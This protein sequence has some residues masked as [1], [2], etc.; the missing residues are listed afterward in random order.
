MRVYFIVYG[1]ALTLVQGCQVYIWALGIREIQGGSKLSGRQGW[2]NKKRPSYTQWVSTGCAPIMAPHHVSLHVWGSLLGTASHIL[3][4]KGLLEGISSCFLVS[5][6]ILEG[7]ASYIFH[8]K[9]TTESMLSYMYGNPRGHF[10]KFSHTQQHPKRHFITFFSICKGSY[11][12]AFSTLIALH[13]TI[14]HSG[15]LEGTVFR[16]GGLGVVRGSVSTVI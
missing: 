2:K 7:T 8:W 3:C 4:W 10:I 11:E 5:R 1:S 13:H 9:G 14:Y 6:S 15:T 12:G 16:G